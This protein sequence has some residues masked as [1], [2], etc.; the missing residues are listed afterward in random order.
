MFKICEVKISAF[1]SRK[2]STDALW[3][4]VFATRK[5]A[6]ATKILDK[7]FGTR[8]LVIN[9][10]IRQLEDFKAVTTNNQFIDYVEKLL[11]MKPDLEALCQSAEI[12]N[13][14]C[15]GRIEENCLKPWE[16]S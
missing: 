15:M 10:I 12:A 11:K 14:A 8:N 1:D 6:N 5:V 2:T 9:D 3:F 4:P 16:I 13:A 7:K